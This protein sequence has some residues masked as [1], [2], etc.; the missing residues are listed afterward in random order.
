LA[1]Q[2]SEQGFN[3]SHTE[4]GEPVGSV[5]TPDVG[6]YCSKAGVQ[7]PNPADTYLC[8]KTQWNQWYSSYC[9]TWQ[10]EQKICLC[11]M[12][13]RDKVLCRFTACSRWWT[14]CCADWARFL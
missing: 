10:A 3:L 12:P 8:L 9:Q 14:F 11:C 1:F 13:G 5:N 2:V 7:S 6:M 4:Q